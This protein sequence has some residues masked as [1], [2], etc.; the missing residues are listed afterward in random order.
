MGSVLGTAAKAAKVFLR[1]S[2]SVA[3]LESTD[4]KQSAPNAR[5]GT[6]PILPAS[7]SAIAAQ[8]ASLSRS[9]AHRVVI[10]ALWRLWTKPSLKHPSARLTAPVVRAA[11]QGLASS[12]AIPTA[13]SARLAIGGHRASVRLVPLANLPATKRRGK[14]LCRSAATHHRPQHRT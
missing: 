8:P 14:N 13:S 6:I 10:T 12:L 1:A 3:L 11:L 2:V 9:P 7:L 4:R 5:P